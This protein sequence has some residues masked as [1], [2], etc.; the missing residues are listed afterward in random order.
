MLNALSVIFL[1]LTF[2]LVF[3]TQIL[4]TNK[5]KEKK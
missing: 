3:V 4:L 2:I 1:I 5:P